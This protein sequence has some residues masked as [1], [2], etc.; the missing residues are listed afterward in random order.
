MH[1]RKDAHRHV[2]RIIAD[3]HFIDFENCAELAIQCFCR[4]V[5]EIQINLVLGVD[6]FAF[7]TDLEDLARGNVARNQVAVS[8]I[9]LFKK[10]ETFLLGN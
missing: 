8:R 1:A 6:A 10:I 5:S 3:K 4:D 9:L 7:E 2:S